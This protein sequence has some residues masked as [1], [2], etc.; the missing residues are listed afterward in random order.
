MATSHYCHGKWRSGS[1]GSCPRHDKLSKKQTTVYRGVG[2]P[3]GR[4]GKSGAAKPKDS[5]KDATK[6]SPKESS[7]GSSSSK[8]SSKGSSSSKESAGD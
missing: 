4:S 2:D 6:A 1:V 3:G 5:K 8:E 7:K